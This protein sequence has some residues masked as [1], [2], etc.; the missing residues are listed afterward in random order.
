MPG[1]IPLFT[2]PRSPALFSSIAQFNASGPWRSVPK[3]HVLFDAAYFADL[4]KAG[5]PEE[6]RWL[7]ANPRHGP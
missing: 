5:M 3:N 7:I 4:R 2:S 6:W 1:A